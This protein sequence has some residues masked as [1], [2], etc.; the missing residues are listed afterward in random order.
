[1]RLLA[2]SLVSTFPTWVF[3]S[4]AATAGLLI[5]LGIVLTASFWAEGF[6]S[7]AGRVLLAT[8]AG[9]YVVAAFRPADVDLNMHIL[10][11]LFVMG[12]G[13]IGLLAAGLACRRGPLRGLRT[14]TL[15]IAA[16]AFTGTILHFGPDHFGL[17]MGGAE[18]IA[19]F[20]PRIW[21]TIAAAVIMRGT[22]DTGMRTIH[23]T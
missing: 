22:R 14:P 17:G 10:G 21:L 20:A 16:P 12:A 13:D 3:N 2:F 19:V 6:P 8:G 1:M 11:A 15:V 5:I 7:A 9:G 4:S 18:R 23:E